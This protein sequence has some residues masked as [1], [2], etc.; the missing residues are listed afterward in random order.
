MC[1]ALQLNWKLP[2]AAAKVDNNSINSNTMK[3]SGSKSYSLR[4]GPVK[5]RAPAV[6]EE[7]RGGRQRRKASA[8]KSSKDTPP[9][10]QGPP[11]KRGPKPRPRPLPMSKYRRKTANLRERQRMGEINNAF[12][13][14][15]S[16]IPE[17]SNLGSGSSAQGGNNKAGDK[18]TKIN[19]LHVAVNYIRAL[20]NIL[21]TGS[22][23]VNVFG[24]AVVQSP[25]LAPPPDTI[26][27]DEEVEVSG[28]KKKSKSDKKSPKKQQPKKTKGKGNI[29]KKTGPENPYEDPKIAAVT[30]TGGGGG[31]AGTGGGC[32]SDIGDA[33]SG[34]APSPSSSSSSNVGD[35][36][37]FDCPDWTELTSTLEFPRDSPGPSD[38]F[39]PAPPLTR[40]NLNAMLNEASGEAT[41][42][43]KVSALQ[44]VAQGTWSKM[45]SKSPPIF[46]DNCGFSKPSPPAFERQSSFPE[47][48]GEDLCSLFGGGGGCGG[49]DDDLGFCAME[50]EGIGGAGGGGKGFMRDEISFVHDEDPFQLIL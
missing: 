15:K 25:E 33:D 22:A 42:L 47:L 3:K 38:L 14:L 35:Q 30:D 6:A 26:F 10:V 21:H 16:K 4:E 24:T 40:G 12:D 37:D 48:A 45:A 32:S 28:G 41:V 36:M 20:E 46:F 5:K 23:G 8:K 49:V 19:V 9:V 31:A 7:Q 29:K 11:K 13:L 50:D 34:I 18:M 2:A 1:E 27:D 43:R 39:P 44:P 17:L